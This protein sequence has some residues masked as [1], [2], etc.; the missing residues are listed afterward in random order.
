MPASVARHRSRS[1]AVLILAALALSVPGLA[2]AQSR[3]ETLQALGVSPREARDVRWRS[4]AR[5]G[6]VL[7]LTDVR[8]G[9]QRWRSVTVTFA[10]GGAAVQSIRLDGLALGRSSEAV[11]SVELYEP[12]GAALRT[13]LQAMAA[14]AET[15]RPTAGE[16]RIA[17][18]VGR[19]LASSEN[20][21]E[22]R[23]D[24]IEIRG[25]THAPA[26]STVD[27][28]RVEGV[29][30]KEADGSTLGVRAME[31][32]GPSANLLRALT[33]QPSEAA[34]AALGAIGFRSLL[35]EGFEANLSER[36]MAE[37]SPAAKPAGDTPPGPFDMRPGRARMSLERL[38]VTDLTADR[39]GAAE[40]AG[41]AMTIDDQAAKPMLTLGLK[42]M[43]LSGVDIAYWRSYAAAFPAF[44]K[45]TSAPAADGAAVAPA[46]AF[47]MPRGGPLDWGLDTISLD[48][49][50]M[51]ITGLQ[52]DLNGFD[53]TS[54]RDAA[55]KVT[56][57][58]MAPTTRLGLST[59]A[60]GA[61]TPVLKAGFGAMGYQS[62]GMSFGGVASWDPAT[63]TA[64]YSD[65]FV[66]MREGFRLDYAVTLGGMSRFMEAAIRMNPTPTSQT[67]ALAAVFD[68]VSVGPM[69]LRLADEGILARTTNAISQGAQPGGA[70]AG[71]SPQ[72]LR[73]GAAQGLETS[74][75]RSNGPEALKPLVAAFAEWL[76]VGGQVEINAAPAQPVS[77]KALRENTAEALKALNLTA[78][79]R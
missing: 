36:M 7:T 22:S 78:R 47:P 71:Q 62:I 11:G 29:R 48:G 60:G 15:R 39:L 43:S 55:G 67:A 53:M 14:G 30:H 6:D 37:G 74:F 35:V 40:V 75:I 73:E 68:A 64:I 18:A 70:G 77:G 16:G 32:A 8:V 41:F 31:V 21:V 3:N 2:S 65:S 76:R 24:L 9:D 72:A 10:P 23:I 58:V 20:G 25:L 44:M 66:A 46:P 42:R 33:R 4:A 38:S 51:N 57:S 59:T 52:I 69:R 54:T 45:A 50:A 61:L 5:D 34:A 28:V 19:N 79:Q 17:R 56:R 1:V 12:Q 13:V 63:D 49:F 27:F 26:Q